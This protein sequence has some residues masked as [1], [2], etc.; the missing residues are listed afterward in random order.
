[1][2]ATDQVGA[3]V[4][5]TF[6][7]SVNPV[8]DNPYVAAPLTDGVTD[9]D[10]NVAVDLTGVFE[11]V[12]IATNGDAL[13][14][15]VVANTNST[16]FDAT[17][18]AGSM[19]SLDLAANLHGDA[20]LTVRATDTAGAF[21]E[22]SFVL[23]VNSVNDSPGVIAPFADLNVDEDAPNVVLDLSGVFGDVDV[24][25]DGDSFV[26]SLGGNSN[27]A[28]FDVVDLTGTTLTLD[29]APEQNGVADITLRATDTQGTS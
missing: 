11:D 2:R 14:Y 24:A 6:R 29:L 22:D 26:L 4:D 15:A 9:E 3:F 20:T 27:A 13:S 25:T 5:D 12:D 16:L 19:L 8:N 18:T 1:M 28:L 17:T 21:V 10:V 23:T 7:V